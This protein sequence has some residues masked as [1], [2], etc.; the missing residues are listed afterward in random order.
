MEP[1]L[2]GNTI[3]QARLNCKMTQ[4]ELAEAVQITPT[5]LKHIESEHRKPSVEVLFS[6]ASILHFSIDALLLPDI[7]PTRTQKTHEILSLIS[8]CTVSEMDVLLAALH[9]LEHQKQKTL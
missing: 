3:R 2:L 4:E 6:L 1:G 7:N 9:E 8:S 5:H